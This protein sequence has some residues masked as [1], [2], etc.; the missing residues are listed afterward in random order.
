VRAGNSIWRVTVL[1]DYCN[2]RCSHNL[3]ITTAD[4]V[5]SDATKKATQHA[6]KLADKYPNPT[7]IKVELIGTIDA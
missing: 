3:L 1:Y 6:E 7:V 2:S 4:C 5:L